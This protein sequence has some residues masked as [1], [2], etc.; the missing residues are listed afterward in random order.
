MPIGVPMLHI[1]H[2]ALHRLTTRTNLTPDHAIWAVSDGTPLDSMPTP[3]YQY[4]TNR[5]TR[6]DTAIYR[7]YK[8]TILVYRPNTYKDTKTSRPLALITVLPLPKYLTQCL[9]D[10]SDYVSIG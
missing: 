9:T 10:N 7:L 4:I 2:H 5:L 6:Y 3:I 1:T 8:D